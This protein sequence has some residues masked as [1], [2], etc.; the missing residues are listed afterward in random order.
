M[1]GQAEAE[2][3][4]TPREPGQH[5]S[6]LILSLEELRVFGEHVCSTGT[7]DAVLSKN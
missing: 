5:G 4:A 3:R 7:E 6:Y 2:E 1:L